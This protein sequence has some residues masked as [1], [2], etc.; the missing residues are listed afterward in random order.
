[1]RVVVADI[2][3]GMAMR[4]AMALLLV[5][6]ADAAAQAMPGEAPAAGSMPSLALGLSSGGV[7]ALNE[8]F[9]EHRRALDAFGGRTSMDRFTNGG[10]ERPQHWTLYG[11]LGVFGFQ[12]QL[13]PERSS[14]IQFK[15]GRTGP[16]LTGKTYIGIH[17]TF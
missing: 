4:S 14:G 12:D 5:A 17:R 10:Y 6:A 11:R 8:E 9:D 2:A 7:R 16:K 1:M 13:D 15:L 3:V